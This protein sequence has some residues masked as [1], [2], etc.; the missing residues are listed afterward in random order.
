INFLNIEEKAIFKRDG[1]IRI[2]QLTHRNK[3]ILFELLDIDSVSCITED[4]EQAYQNSYLEQRMNVEIPIRYFNVKDLR[5][6]QIGNRPYIV[7]DKAYSFERGLDVK[8][9]SESNFDINN[10]LL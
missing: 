1:N 3:S 10:Q 9:I 5:Q 8:Q 7:P 4:D 6:L 2:D